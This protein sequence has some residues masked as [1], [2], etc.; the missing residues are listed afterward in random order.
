LFTAENA[1]SAEKDYKEKKKIFSVFS[2]FSAV[3]KF[4]DEASK[5]PRARDGTGT[6]WS[7]G[8]RAV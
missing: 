6:E 5:G 7:R 1:E 3:N 2:A 8:S 4:R